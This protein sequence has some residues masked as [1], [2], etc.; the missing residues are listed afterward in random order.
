M[1]PLTL[2]NP[3]SKCLFN[4]YQTKVSNLSAN[5]FLIHLRFFLFGEIS[6]WICNSSVI[7]ISVIIQYYIQLC[8]TFPSIL[9]SSK[10]T[11]TQIF[12]PVGMASDVALNFENLVVCFAFKSFTFHQPF[13]PTVCFTVAV[14][15][16]KIQGVVFQKSLCHFGSYKIVSQIFISS[17]VSSQCCVQQYIKIDR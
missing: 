13:A 7:V 2:P 6:F 1:V 5:I 11:Y 14:F 9:F 10:F 8:F 12:Q 17:I 16:F 3:Y 15:Y 4:P